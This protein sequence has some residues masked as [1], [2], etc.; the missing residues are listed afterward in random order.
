MSLLSPVTRSA[1]LVTIGVAALACYQDKPKPASTRQAATTAAD[2][3]AGTGTGLQQLMTEDTALRELTS[4]HLTMDKL[5]R[6]ATAQRTLNTLT[7]TDPTIVRSMAQQGAPH[8]LDQMV[9]RI[10]AQ[11]QLHKGIVDAGLSSREFVIVMFALRQ[12]MEG[13]MLKQGG[14]LK[15]AR[16]PPSVMD[17]IAFVEHNLS[18]IN[19]LVTAMGG[20]PPMIPPERATPPAPAPAP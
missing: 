7:K 6:F 13:Y 3:S 4:Y 11:P 18:Q 8:S 17:N 1:V 14:Q 2:S 9:A 19:Q 20:R 10:D 16:V 5:Q 12:A 15:A